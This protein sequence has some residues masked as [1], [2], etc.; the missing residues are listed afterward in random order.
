MTRDDRTDLYWPAAALLHGA[1]AGSRMLPR[2]EPAP[3]P[4]FRTLDLSNS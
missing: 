2:L 4:F 1:M 3:W